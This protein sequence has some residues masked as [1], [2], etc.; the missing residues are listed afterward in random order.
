MRDII[1][2]VSN[3]LIVDDVPCNLML[4]ADIIQN[5][6]YNARSA[7]SATQALNDIKILLPDLI[8]IDISMPEIDGFELCLM[9]KKNSTTKDIPVIFISALSSAEYRIKGFR[10][11]AV[12]FIVKPFEREEVSLR[13]NAHLKNYKRQQELEKYNKRLYKIIQEQ[14]GKNYNEQKNV[15]YALAKI[16]TIRE[17]EDDGHIERI[18]KY[19][20]K[21]SM[22]MQLSSIYKDEISNSFIDTIE[23][24]APLHDIGKM[25]ISDSILCNKIGLTP[26]E[27]DIIMKHPVFGADILSDIYNSTEENDFIKMAITIARHHHENW[28]GS[29]Y[30]DGLSGKDIPFC[31]RIVAIVNKYDV[32]RSRK[33]YKNALSH[34]ECMKIINEKSGKKFDPNMV[35][36]FNRIQHKL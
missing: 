16:S 35:D 25:M 30:P 28:D 31:A 17:W 12:D 11:G 29:G 27:R 20:R 19:S 14:I 33:C 34:E 10:L 22:A 1:H 32:L 36:I 24:A 2:E 9:L 7:S 26:E 8:L 6:G 18:S 3:V 5:A 23:L 15:L 4:L 21:L 13:V